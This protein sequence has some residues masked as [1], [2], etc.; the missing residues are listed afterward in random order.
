M[1]GD[2]VFVVKNGKVELRK[3]TKGSVWA[4][5]IEITSGL[6]PGEEIIVEGTE[7]F[8]DGQAVTTEE[9]PSDAVAPKQ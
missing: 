1:N 4:R 7:G 3:V 6:E 9:H 5:G 2:N 8:H